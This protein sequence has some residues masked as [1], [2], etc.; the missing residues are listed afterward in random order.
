[1]LVPFRTEAKCYVTFTKT[2]KTHEITCTV[3]IS[4][5]L[6][7]KYNEDANED[8]TDTE[9][10]VTPGDPWDFKKKVKQ[11]TVIS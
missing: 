7:L 5:D 9:C 11:K 10:Y 3:K 1:M 4:N 6:E 2:E 8:S